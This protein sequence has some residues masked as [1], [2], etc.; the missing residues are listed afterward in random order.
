M[1]AGP[2]R[3]ALGVARLRAMHQVKDG[4]AIFTD[5]FAVPLLG[6]DAD[7]LRRREDPPLMRRVRRF[8]AA[9]SRIGEAFLAR[10]VDRGVRQAVI[11]GAGLDTFA[12]RNPHAAR[13]LRVFEVDHPATQQHKRARMAAASLAAPDCLVFVPVDFERDDLAMA[14]HQAGFDAD[15][16]CFFLWLGVVA[17]LSREAIDATLRTIGGLADAEV[18]FDCTEPPEAYPDVLRAFVAD[19]RRRVA[20]IGEP[21]VSH[22]RSVDLDPL[23]RA[24]GFTDC[25]DLDGACIEAWLAEHAPGMPGPPI[26]GSH[27]VRARVHPRLTAGPVERITPYLPELGSRRP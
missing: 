21:W 20:S 25:E 23:L 10:A 2:S 6:E 1:R 9:R 27:L 14:L 24:H 4:G 18:V 13:G 3:T 26:A 16:P 7:A 11:L 15:A 8:I 17:Y 5:P 12:L 19:R 22:F